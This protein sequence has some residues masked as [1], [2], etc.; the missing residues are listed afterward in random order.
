MEKENIS[1]APFV[2]A[3]GAGEAPARAQKGK[4]TRAAAVKKDRNSRHKQ[5]KNAVKRMLRADSAQNI[6]RQGSI[7]G[8]STKGGR[9]RREPLRRPLLQPR[10]RHSK[11]QTQRNVEQ[12]SPLKGHAE[13]GHAHAK[14]MPIWKCTLMMKTAKFR[15]TPKTHHPLQVPLRHRPCLPRHPH[16]HRRV[17]LLLWAVVVPLMMRQPTCSFFVERLKNS[18]T[19]GISCTGN[20]SACCCR[21]VYLCHQQASRCRR[22]LVQPS[23]LL[24]HAG[25]ICRCNLRL[26]QSH[27]DRL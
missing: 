22:L 8:E 9:P 6:S 24:A 17:W 16:R 12:R 23:G 13:R 7:L 20:A 11:L 5:F 18:K 19:V 4:K 27:R 26:Q 2:F 10:L 14:A 1:N 15:P 3:A 21:R 25:Q